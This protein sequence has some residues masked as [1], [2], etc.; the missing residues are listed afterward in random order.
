M[1]RLRP[2]DDLVT[3]G[4]VSSVRTIAGGSSQTNGNRAAL[5]KRYLELLTQL[6]PA[7]ALGV[8][9]VL[10]AALAA[11]SEPKDAYQPT[12]TDEGAV[13]E[14]LSA[15][16]EA[17]SS[18]SEQAI[19]AAKSDGRLAWGNWG[20]DWHNHSPTTP[21]SNGYRPPWSNWSNSNHWRNGSD[22]GGRYSH[23]PSVPGW[24]LPVAA[25]VGIAGIGA[26]A[27]NQHARHKHKP[28]SPSVRITLRTDKGR[29]RLIRRRRSP[30]SAAPI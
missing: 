11:A 9:L 27:L 14:R 6:M 5:S 15:I 18:I 10:G 19:E 3:T 21:W 30:P 12:R 23:S 25:V 13:S 28:K 8:S 1:P 2:I 4:L 7:G 17:V 16:R 20:S 24:L 29:V 26:F 22:G